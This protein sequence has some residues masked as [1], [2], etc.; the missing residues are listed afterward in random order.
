MNSPHDTPALDSP[1]STPNDSEECRELRLGTLAA[2]FV[3]RKRQGEEPSIEE[4][5]TRHPDLADSIDDLFPMV[6]RLE[7]LKEQDGSGRAARAVVGLPSIQ[8]LGDFRILREIGRGGMGVVFE[9]EQITLRR[10]VALKVLGANIAATPAQFTRFRREAEAA[11]RLHHTNIVPVYGI[12]VDHGVH[13]Y[14]M[15]FIDGWPLSEVIACLS[16]NDRQRPAETRADPADPD[17]LD[18]SGTAPAPVVVEQLRETRTDVVTQVVVAP[19]GRRSLTREPAVAGLRSPQ[20]AARLAADLADAVAYAHSQGVLHR[21]IKPANILLDRQG[22]AWLVDFGLA[23]H[24]D[25]DSLTRTGNVVGTVQYMAP[26]Q[27]SDAFDARSDVFSL[28][29]TLYE[30]LGRTP[31]YADSNQAALMRRRVSSPPPALRTHARNIPRDLETVVM[32]ACALNPA[33][34]YSSAAEF[35]GDLRRFIAG[36]PIRAR[37]AN[38]LHRLI[39]WARRHPTVAG[40]SALA[41]TLLLSLMASLAVGKHRTQLALDEM[42]IQKRRAEGNL[43]VAIGVLDEIMTNVSERGIPRTLRLNLEEGGAE[44]SDVT[45]SSADSDLLTSLL[46]FYDRFAAENETSLDVETA[47][48]HSRIGDIEMRL[49][50]LD[51]AAEAFEKSI[52][53][54]ERL[55]T[56]TPGN[57]DLLL[58][59]ATALNQLGIVRAGSGDIPDAIDSH[60]MAR[61]LLEGA[62]DPSRR[63]RFELAQTLSLL[64]TVGWRAGIRE[65]FAG[66]IANAS[67]QAFLSGPPPRGPD[68]FRP[69]PSRPPEWDQ[70]PPG[71]GPRPGRPPGPPPGGPPGPTMNPLLPILADLNE[72]ARILRQ[73]TA[74]DAGN[75]D[76]RLALARVDLDRREFVQLG[77]AFIPN[78]TEPASAAAAEEIL[79]GLVEEF[80]DSPKYRFELAETLAARSRFQ[81]ELSPEQREASLHESAELARTLT[82]AYP[83]IWGYVALEARSQK[84]LAVLLKGQGALPEACARFDQARAIQQRLASENPTSSFYQVAYAQM[85]SEWSDWQWELGD[86]AGAAASLQEALAVAEKSADLWGGDFLFRSFLESLRN[87]VRQR[88]ARSTRDPSLLPPASENR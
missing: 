24:A 40:L 13:F 29:L 54:Y 14:A 35:S 65:I 16:E 78:Q 64:G 42:E 85:L 66:L 39:R 25:Q 17:G 28:G 53:L 60:R 61:T 50:H 88:E 11:A 74:E 10:R 49:G 18:A 27:F 68:R 37:R 76:Y 34:R 82:A 26:E 86:D 7:A 79:R 59:H 70:R 5:K 31:A 75:P 32:K 67:T 41:L 69:Q 3:E 52:S 46:Q 38:P 36:D 71:P 44:Y 57:E 84:D 2:E 12:G 77:P 73:L 72:S 83:R 80:P 22:V 6:A 48:A 33:D 20:A 8:Q 30:L 4:Y 47:R 63:I 81:N 15:Q 58:A 62:D 51:R 9:A 23:K 56:R 45:L 55:R 1:A 87:R 21:D 19:A 43:T